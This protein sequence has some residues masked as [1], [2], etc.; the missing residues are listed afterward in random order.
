MKHDQTDNL[1][2]PKRRQISW[3]REQCI[4]GNCLHYCCIL[5]DLCTRKDGSELHFWPTMWWYEIQRTANWEVGGWVVG[6]GWGCGGWGVGGL[7]RKERWGQK[8]HKEG[9]KRD[10]QALDQSTNC[11]KWQYTPVLTFN[12]Y[13]VSHGNWCTATLWNRI[14]TAQCEGMG[15]V[16]SAR[17]EP[18]LLPPC[19]SI[20]VLSYCNCQEIHS[21]QQ[22][23]LAV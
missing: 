21:R 17:Y 23:G 10:Q 11:H 15:E 16:G 13:S 3:A 7:K 19:P 14:V 9:S 12:S 8:D 5:G 4:M 6:W 1:R 2:N 20:R 22:A 18:A